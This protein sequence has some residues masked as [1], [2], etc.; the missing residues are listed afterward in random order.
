MKKP[1]DFSA[2][3][4]SVAFARE[5]FSDKRGKGSTQ[6]VTLSVWGFNLGE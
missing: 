3:F 1:A 4:F 2:G 5:Q 6:V